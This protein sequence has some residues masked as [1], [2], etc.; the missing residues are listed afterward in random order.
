ML[1]KMTLEQLKMLISSILQCYSS[2]Q[3]LPLTAT[4]NISVSLFTFRSPNDL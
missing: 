3:P 2:V 1:Q 4:D